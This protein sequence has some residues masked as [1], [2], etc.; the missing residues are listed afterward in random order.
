MDLG[1]RVSLP[2]DPP[3]RAWE[4]FKKQAGRRMFAATPDY[5]LKG[6]LPPMLFGIVILEIEADADGNL[7]RVA[8][9]RAPANAAAADTAEIA[10]EVVRRGAPY[11]DMSRLPKPW[12]WSEVFLFDEKRRFRPRSME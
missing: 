9:T 6:K 5:A 8:V 2:G 10:M 12:K 7:R 1:A 3:A 4:P 11:G